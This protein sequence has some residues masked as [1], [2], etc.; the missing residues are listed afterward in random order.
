MVRVPRITINGHDTSVATTADLPDNPDH[1]LV[2]FC[3]ADKKLYVWDATY[4]DY[5]GS[6][7]SSA[8]LD[9]VT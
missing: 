4:N 6:W 2:V 5:E 8:A 1:G 3:E 7:Y 9:R